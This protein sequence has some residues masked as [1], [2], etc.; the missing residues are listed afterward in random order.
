MPV[1]STYL[2]HGNVTDTY[3]YLSSTPEL[4]VAAS[5][6]IETRWKGVA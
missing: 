3:W 5:K 4:I 2:G 1:L 6:L